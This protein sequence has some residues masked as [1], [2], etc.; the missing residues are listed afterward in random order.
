MVVEMRI[1]REKSE[2]TQAVDQTSWK[3]RCLAVLVRR[4]PSMRPC[5]DVRFSPF[6][7][8]L[9]RTV[10][11]LLP[12]CRVSAVP[13]YATLLVRLRPTYRLYFRCLYRA[14]LSAATLLHFVDAAVTRRCL[15][16][17]GN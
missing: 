6:S 7:I 14:P 13:P 15:Y 17:R 1:R 3:P 8:P 4:P 5:L 2:M 11:A 16:V 10:S 9:F 12:L